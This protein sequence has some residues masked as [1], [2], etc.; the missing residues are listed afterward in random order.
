M[1]VYDLPTFVCLFAFLLLAGECNDADDLLNITSCSNMIAP[2]AVLY[3]L[4]RSTCLIIISIVV[5][6]LRSEMNKREKIIFL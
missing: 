6:T 4:H 1:K 2:D 5:S 3:T